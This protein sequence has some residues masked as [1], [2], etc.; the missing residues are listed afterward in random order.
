VT[1]LDASE[2][3]KSRMR[4]YAV[5][6]VALVI[7]VVFGAW[8]GWFLFF[9]M[10]ERHTV[11]HFMNAVIAGDLDRGYQL[12]KPHGTSYS[13]NDFSGDWGPKGYY[14]PLKSYR[15]ESAEEPKDA[16]GVV[17]VIETSPFQPFPAASDPN[18]GR[19][20][21]VRLWVERSDQSLSFP[22]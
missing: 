3:P 6:G 18:S 13:F 19:N 2:E 14:S 9:F 11:E 22:P 15:I 16:S 20:R 12:W 8:Y 17:V 7:F 1:L 10:P 4:R 21:E 5:S